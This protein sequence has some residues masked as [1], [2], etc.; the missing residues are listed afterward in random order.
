LDRLFSILQSVRK[1]ARYSGGEYGSYIKSREEVELRFAFCFPDVY[2]IGM[3]HLGLRIIYEQLNQM[4]GVW[5]E[6]AF[7][8]WVDMEQAL[9]ENSL[10]LYALESGDALS[11]FDVIGFTLQYELSYT[12]MLNMLE[13]GGIPLLSSQREGLFPLVIAGGPCTC[14]PE[15]VADFIDLFFVGEAEEFL[16]EFIELCKKAK[17]EGLSKKE[18]LRRASE[19][20][21]VYVPR[22]YEVTYNENKTIASFRAKEGFPQKIERAIV[23]DLDRA[24]I[25][26]KLIVPST[27]VVH[28]RAMLELF[29]GCIRGCRFCQAGHIT[30]PVRM[31]SPEVM[32]EQGK[33]LIA[34]SGCEELSLTS[35]ST[36]DYPGLEPL[37]DEL[38]EEFEGK[39]VNL[40]LPSLRADSFSVDLM[41]KVQKV[42]KSG[43]T[44][45]PEAGTQRLRDVIN[46]N[47][48]EEDVLNACS[49]AFNA[50]WNTVKLYFMMGLP[51]ETTEDIRAIADIA[52]NVRYRFM[53]A[54]NRGKR[55]VSISVST[56]LFVPK[57]HTPFQWEGQDS[58]EESA[59]K[60][61]VLR[62]EM[63]IKGVKYSW[64]DA[65]MSHLEAIFARGDRRLG[66][67]IL[68]AFRRGCRFDGWNDQLKFDTWIQTMEDLGLD[69]AFYV[70][71]RRSFD[72]ILPW[73][74]I[75]M[76]ITKEFLIR[77]AEAAYRGEVSPD[78]LRGCMACGAA[79]YAQ[80]GACHAG[81]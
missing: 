75:D 16:P 2:E 29:R 62:G 32:A 69:A 7:A 3:S 53:T 21:G 43:L 59:R 22:F 31:H 52:K 56:S 12:N 72:E 6:R 24:F 26:K 81:N 10:P 58:M 49:M 17:R 70:N 36:S 30:R 57:P 50:G 51:T 1:P 41:E 78:C 76:G 54:E 46:K 63:R 79:K 5:C 60:V 25:P 13:L 65:K 71:R 18:F 14:N 40:S 61:E 64:H 55:G 8:P 20:T 33:G 34:F 77:E 11:E 27:E 45:A 74:H 37:C 73:D 44:F 42:R 38:L 68:E 19:I 4:Q 23:R 47:I 15:P 35:L 28:D 67:V 48:R 80:G 66:P 39:R 9:R